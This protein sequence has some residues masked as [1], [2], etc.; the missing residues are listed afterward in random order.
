[1][2]LPKDANTG[3]GRDAVD[4]S[5]KSGTVSYA[6]GQ[7]SVI[8]KVA[9]RRQPLFVFVPMH[10]DLP[11]RFRFERHPNLFA[12]NERSRANQW[13]TSA[14]LPDPSTDA[15]L[16]DL[17]IKLTAAPSPLIYCAGTVSK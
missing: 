4:V 17:P 2:H 1:M 14:D 11:K 10:A 5:T 9:D 3:C 16:G 15:S 8:F 13:M 6:R 12:R 7:A